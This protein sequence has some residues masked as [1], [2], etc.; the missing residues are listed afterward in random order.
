MSGCKVP[1]CRV[2]WKLTS[3]YYLHLPYRSN[4]QQNVWHKFQVCK[5]FA[6]F[7]LIWQNVLKAT[8]KYII[9][10]MKEVFQK[11]RCHGNVSNYE[12]CISKSNICLLLHRS[13][14]HCANSTGTSDQGRCLN[15]DKNITT[16]QMSFSYH[17]EGIF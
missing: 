16:F 11:V 12:A 2:F 5:N 7:S 3:P 10:F 6:K 17:T 13:S 1:S 15:Q 14:C 9:D 8:S 4:W